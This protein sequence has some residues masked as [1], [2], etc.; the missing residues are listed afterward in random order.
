MAQHRLTISVEGNISSG[1]T[2]F[3]EASVASGIIEEMCPLDP[4]PR[5]KIIFEPVEQWQNVNGVNVLKQALEDP[6]KMLQLQL[7]TLLTRREHDGLELCHGAAC[8]CG[9]HADP[10]TPPTDLHVVERAGIAGCDHCI[11]GARALEKELINGA[12]AYIYTKMVK[13]YLESYC[14]DERPH[15]IVYLRTP[16]EVCH[17]RIAQ[18]SRPGEALLALDDLRDLHE[19]HERWLTGPEAPPADRVIVLDGTRPFHHD[20]ALLRATWKDILSGITA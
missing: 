7:V 2:S 12:N 19:R 14:A 1:K 4:A 16:P 3:L 20:R 18:R 5:I 13:L 8:R 6:D 10:G 9:R 15:T 17:Q 11:F